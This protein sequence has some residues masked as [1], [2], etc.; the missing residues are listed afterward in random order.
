MAAKIER[1]DAIGIISGSLEGT[2]R[3]KYLD[4]DEDIKVGDKV[5]SSGKNSRFPAGIPVGVVAKISRERSGLTL[6]AIVKP[7]VNLSS[8]EE[9]LV[10]TNY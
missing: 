5:V 9:V 2:C 10:I 3:L 8:L 1:S 7:M 6:F 4:L